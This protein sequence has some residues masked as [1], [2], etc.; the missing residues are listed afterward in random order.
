MEE[1]GCLRT[2]PIDLIHGVV[3]MLK[4]LFEKGMSNVLVRGRAEEGNSLSI[5]K[6]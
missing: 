1:C 4:W 2:G 6:K 5:G 3:G